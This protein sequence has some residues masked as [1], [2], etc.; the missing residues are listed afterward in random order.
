[1]IIVMPEN[2]QDIINVCFM[3]HSVFLFA[4]CS[5]FFV[6]MSCT[7]V[8]ELF[9]QGTWKLNVYI[10]YTYIKTKTIRTNYSE[11]EVE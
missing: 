10:N 4:Y 5:T 11:W 8:Y 9:A 1:M 3:E 6:S 7:K 2:V